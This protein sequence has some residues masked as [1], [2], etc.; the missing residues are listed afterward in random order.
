VDA[1]LRP[2]GENGVLVIPITA[3]RDYFEHRAQFWEKQALTKA[4]ALFGPEMELLRDTVTAIWKRAGEAPDL[5]QQIHKMYYRITKERVKGDDVAHFKT[6]KGG[7][8]G[9]EFLVQYLQMKNCVMETNT[10]GAIDRLGS[11]LEGAQ[12]DILRSS[13]VFLRR[14]ESVLRRASNSSVSQLPSRKEELRA[15][16]FRLGL[17]SEKEFFEVYDLRRKQAQEI[18]EEY[19]S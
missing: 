2:E 5:K 15:L 12:G 8:I 4:R 10:L 13:Y 6:G 18:I 3:Y 19:L 17:A 1:R 9:I 11:I 16:A 7:L 14:I